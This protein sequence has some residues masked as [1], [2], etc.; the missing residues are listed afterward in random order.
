MASAPP[1]PACSTTLHTAPISSLQ[2][3]QPHV[4]SRE[5]EQHVGSKYVDQVLDSLYVI[6]WSINRP[7]GVVVRPNYQ[8]AIES[9]RLRSGSGPP[10]PGR[11]AFHSGEVWQ[12]IMKLEPDARR[13]FLLPAR[14]C[15]IS[16]ETYPPAARTQN[17]PAD[18]PFRGNSGSWRCSPLMRPGF[19]AGATS[20]RC[21][22]LALDSLT[23]TKRKCRSRPAD[24]RG[25]IRLGNCL[26]LD[27]A[28]RTGDGDK[29]LAGAADE[30]ALGIAPGLRRL[31]HLA[32]FRF[33]YCYAHNTIRVHKNNDR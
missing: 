12:V 17:A 27:L 2:R 30:F 16:A 1:P 26:D 21:V 7:C 8:P 24:A 9:L 25:R 22:V 33:T 19:V 13:A 6:E 32:A 3:R 18:L 10:G 4:D 14:W 28:A 15:V 31:G 11:W 23:Q 29:L 20:C 5:A